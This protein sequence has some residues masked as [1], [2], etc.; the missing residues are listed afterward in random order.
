MDSQTLELL[1]RKLEERVVKNCADI[2]E[3]SGPHNLN[4]ATSC[5]K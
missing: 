3:V 1:N 5:E 2:S 4:P